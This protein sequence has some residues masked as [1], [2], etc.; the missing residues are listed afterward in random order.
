MFGEATAG[1]PRSAL[2]LGLPS[3]EVE[4]T[5]LGRV[6]ARCPAQAFDFQY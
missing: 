5:A 1:R 2:G 3:L 6:L 4:S